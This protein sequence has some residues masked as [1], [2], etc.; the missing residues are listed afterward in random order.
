MIGGRYL[1]P[2]GGPAAQLRLVVDDRDLVEW[3]VAAS[4]R[5]FVRWIDLDD[6]MLDGEGD[7]A[8]L[9]VRV[10]TA[11]GLGT[12]PPVGLEQFDVAGPD[13]V[14]TALVT[15]WYEREEDPSTGRVWR[16]TSA[17]SAL[18]IR[19]PARDVTLVLAGESPLK[20]FDTAPV[21]TVRAGEQVLTTFEPRAD[22]AETIPVPGD[23]WRQANGLIT[24]ETDRTF[25][26]SDSGS[27]DR[28]ELGLRLY[29]VRI[30]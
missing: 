13:A 28:R 14:M 8:R 9:A 25:R 19:G 22:F 7:Y 5:W 17:S 18:E 23:A 29:D 2:D 16:W 21:V 6:G 12:A 20:Y 30:E 11:S 4:S 26:P 10:T 15:G 24:I 1:G 27:P 3:S